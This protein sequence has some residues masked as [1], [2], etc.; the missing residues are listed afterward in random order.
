VRFIESTDVEALKEL[1]ERKIDFSKVV[2]EVRPIVQEVRDKGDEA[3]KRFTQQFDKRTLQN[4]AVAMERRRQAETQV[5]DR[6]KEALAIA[7]ENIWRF[8]AAQMPQEWWIEVM[9]GIRSGQLVRPLEKIGCYIP[10]GTYPLVST[11]LMTLLP[12]KVAGVKQTVVCTPK[13]SPEILYACTLCGADQVF[14]VGGPMAIAGMAYGTASI[15]K[16]DKIVGPGNLY[17]TA[18]KKLVYG[19]VGIDFLAGPSELLVIA[20]AAAQPSF[21][22][23]DLLAQAEHD[24]SAMVLCVTPSRE[25]AMGVA[26]EVKARLE[27]LSTRSIAES[28]LN[29]RG[30]IVVVKDLEEAFSLSNFLA[31]E[32]L[33]LHLEDPLLWIDAIENAGSIFLGS[34]SAEAAGD[35]A[36][37]PNH[38]LPTGGC[39]AAQSG[40]SVRDFIKMPTVQFLTKEGLERIAPAVIALAEAEGLTGHAESLAL[41]TGFDKFDPG[42]LAQSK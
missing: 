42:A 11:V 19:D 39:A 7:K 27:W 34:Y 29:S 41:R 23:A 10:G 3:I 33:E 37:G 22:A 15:P 31:P 14:E 26:Q 30:G 4:M 38:V 6:L 16:V 32:H 24:L 35:Y 5:P 13:A 20:D 9:P 36:S 17:V 40:L 21:I 28:S 1:K 18:A 2:E 8:H 12:A 25:L